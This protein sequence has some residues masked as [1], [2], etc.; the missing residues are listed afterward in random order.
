MAALSAVIFICC[1]MGETNAL[2]PVMHKLREKQIDFQIIAMGASTVRLN[3]DEALKNKLITVKETVNTA[4]NRAKPIENVTEIIENLHPLVVISGPASK[5][6]EQ[7]LQ[8]IAAHKKIVFLDNFNYDMTNPAWETVKGV[9][10]SAQKIICV[11]N[12]V[13]EQVQ[14][15]KTLK[16]R[17]KDIKA[18]GRPSIEAESKKVKEVNKN[19]VLQKIGFTGDQP[20]VTFIGGYGPRYDNGVN[21]AYAEAEKALKAEGYQVHIQHH[22]NVKKEQPLETFEAVGMADFIICYDSTVGFESLFAN[23][24]VIYLQPDS[25]QPY[26]N[27]AIDNKLAVKVHT[28]QELLEALKST[29]IEKKDVFKV[30]GVPENSTETITNY[31]LKKVFR[32]AIFLLETNR[33]VLQVSPSHSTGFLQL[34]N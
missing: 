21:Q 33:A 4:E 34:K 20:I 7:L 23:K 29:S 22:P 27:L 13:K 8:S 10:H 26:H 30:L 15:L 1:D 2:I 32:S 31:I 9:A 18:L 24:T 12:I 11:S 6:Q 5:A 3:K 16:L 25:V 17:D 28:T 14:A 19:E